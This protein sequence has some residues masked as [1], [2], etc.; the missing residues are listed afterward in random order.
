MAIEVNVLVCAC[1]QS[2]L[3]STPSDDP[4]REIWCTLDLSVLAKKLYNMCE[5]ASCRVHMSSAPV[6][7]SDTYEKDLS[8]A[9]SH[10]FQA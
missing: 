2:A 1:S 5:L 7:T 9:L 6:D 8:R 4:V 10:I 3:S